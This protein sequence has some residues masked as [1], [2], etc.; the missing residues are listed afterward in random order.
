MKTKSKISGHIVRS[1][2][3]AV[4]LSVAFI[5]FSSASDSP[6]TWHKS[7]SDDWR[8]WQH[9]EKSEPTP[10]AQLHRACSVSA[11]N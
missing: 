2:A 4:F 6:N 8:L 11:S 3:Y 7:A 9:G 5:A 10:S 1:A